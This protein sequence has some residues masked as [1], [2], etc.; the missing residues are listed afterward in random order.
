M[1]L[2]DP[3][4]NAIGTGLSKLDGTFDRIINPPLEDEQASDQVGGALGQATPS[5]EAAGALIDIVEE[6]ILA[7]LQEEGQISPGEVERLADDVE[8]GAASVLLGIASAST[9]AE[10]LSLG[11]VEG[12]NEFLIQALAGLGVDDVTG[13][14]LEVR[15]AEGVTPALQQMVNAEHRSKQVDLQDA[16]EQDLR[17][18]DSD[19]G[20]IDDIS[21]Y[22]IKPSQVGLLEEV[23][24]NGMEFEE[25]IETP[26]E[27]GLVVPDAVINAELDRSG[28]AEPTKD[29]LSQVNNRIPRS[30]RSYEE[31]IVS[32]DL[33]ADLD[34]RVEDGTLTPGEALALVPSQLETDTDALRRRWEDKDAL[35]PQAPSQSD[36]LAALTEGYAGLDETR[37]RL[38]QTELDTDR[39]EDVLQAEIVGDLDGSLQAAVATGR[40]SEG[41]FSDLAEF[42]GLDD[43]S[44][45][46][47]LQG[48]SFTDIVGRT[49][50]Q[51]ADPTDRSVRT[52]LGVGESRAA[53]L[54]AV[55]IETVQDLANADPETVADATQTSPETAA[56]YINQAQQRIQ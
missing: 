28:Y 15:M 2:L 20:Y 38:D 24:I 7:E 51:Q 36:F 50:A 11:Q 1:G 49:L 45:E 48:L 25:L 29:F 18:K 41:E 30:T 21:S 23:A 22:G 17:N 13:T 16:I 9:A 14:E 12:Q 8:G 37:E 40:L 55:G 43:Q 4:F 10:A 33:I 52:I 3:I 5:S 42:A 56:E 27:L 35:D 47:L 34:S 53:G 6:F 44:I 46:W 31:L 39:Y 19:S 32:E 26:A 54:V